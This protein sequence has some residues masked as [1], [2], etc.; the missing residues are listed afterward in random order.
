MATH[1]RKI[2]RW[3]PLFISAGLIMVALAEADV[4]AQW[5]TFTNE[6][7]VRMPTGA[8]LNDPAVST[9]DP[10][11]KHYAWDDVDHDG[12]ID[13]AVGRKQ[14][15]TS[16][17]R[18][19]NVLFM[20]EGIAEGHSINGVLVDRSAQ[21]IP[22]FL[23]L[24]NDRDIVMADVDNDT[25]V[26]I[27][28]A[29]AYGQGLPT[30]ISHPRVYM[31]QGE[32][33]GVWQGYVYEQPRVPTFPS[34]PN[35]CGAFAGDVTGDGSVDLSF[36]DYDNISPN[37]F[38]DRL[39][40]N[41]G[42]GF[43][44][45]E[46]TLRMTGAMLDSGFGIYPVIADMNDDGWNDIVKNENGVLEVFNNGGNGFFNILENVPGGAPYFVSVGDLN[47]DNRLDMITSDDGT[48]RYFLNTGNGGNG[49]ADFA[50]FTFP[51]VTNGFGSDSYA[52]D[53]NQD[54]WND[55][56]IGDLDVD[57]AQCP[58]GNGADILR[59]NGNPPNVTFQTAN[60]GIPS[61]MLN[62]VHDFGIFDING[63]TWLDLVVGRCTGTQVWVN[64]P[65]ISMAFSYPDGLPEATV[66]PNQEVEITVQFTANGDTLDPDSP[67]M[68]VSVNDGEFVSTPLTPISENQ[69]GGTLPAVSCYETISFYFTAQM[70][71]GLTFSDPSTAPGVTY[72][73]M[74]ATG[75]EL[76]LSDTLEGDVST[77]SVVN[78]GPISS[79]EWEHV[80]PIGTVSPVDGSLAAPQDDATPAGSMAFVT[81]NG[82][83]GGAASASDV[84]GGPT[85]L[86]SPTIDLQGVDAII[87]YSRWVYSAFGIHDSLTTYVSNNGGTT[88][89][90][91]DTS[92]ATGSAWE[93]FSFLASAYVEPTSNVRVRFGISDLDGSLTEAGIDDFKVETII[94]EGTPCPADLNGGGSVGAEDLALLLGA[95]GPNAGH[96][97]DLNGNG[98]V[99]AEDLALLLGA[100]G[101][102]G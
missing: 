82:A 85:Y 67:T 12:D 36:V 71:G 8:G 78:G 70:N 26:D 90:T 39:L 84:D 31:N 76:L 79:G 92:T 13:L 57:I 29:P 44:T 73:V 25:W 69:Y 80:D 22:G 17:G 54:G 96:P 7:S 93:S 86:L 63:D 37:T 61:S 35:F 48:D 23:D 72:G 58:N 21:Y 60:G 68:Y 99:G 30:S 97:A 101:A 74:A 89:V 15:F 28:T 95:W 46:S 77:W 64:A 1:Q 65:P 6:T 18:K 3:R 100:W 42:N 59:N 16:A 52:V 49:M 34:W 66:L 55:V 41:D 10:E 19:R 51:A 43:F 40:I 11:E 9:T 81:E 53:L 94:C 50:Q 62:G 2:R 91:V 47:N 27:I 14:P 4:S 24:T 56:L 20:N 102:C 75:T 45:D 98:T 33:D 38:D 5:V 88:W 83:V 87:S 32:I